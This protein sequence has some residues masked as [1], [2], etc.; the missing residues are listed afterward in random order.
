MK[1]LK[2]LLLAGAMFAL[3]AVAEA[4]TLGLLD[5]KSVV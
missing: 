5:R 1:I 4:R 3:P 2:A